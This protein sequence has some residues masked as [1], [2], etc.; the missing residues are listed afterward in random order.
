[1][2][3]ASLPDVEA[4]SDQETAMHFRCTP[5][6]LAVKLSLFEKDARLILK[7]S[8]NPFYDRISASMR[9]LLCA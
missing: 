3:A 4:L 6:G 2:T 9:G 8:K 1:M 5:V 7:A